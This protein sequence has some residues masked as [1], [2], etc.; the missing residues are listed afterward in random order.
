MNKNKCIPSFLIPVLVVYITCSRTE[1][2][3]S[4]Q[5]TH[6][7]VSV[8]VQAESQPQSTYL[9]TITADDMGKIGPNE[10]VGGET[11]RLYV[12]EGRRRT[13]SF[14]RYNHEGLLTDT[15]TSIVDISPGINRVAVSL[16][17][18]VSVFTITYD[19]NEFT[20]GNLPVD[21]SEYESGE[22]VT[23]MERGNLTKDGFCFSEWNSAADGSGRSYY[24]GDTLIVDT[25]DIRLY[26]LWTQPAVVT[27]GFDKNDSAATGIMD[28]QSIENGS[29]VSLFPN[30]FQKPGWTFAGW[31]TT[32]DGEVVFEDEDLISRA[33]ED[34]TLYAQWLEIA[35][36]TVAYDGN[37]NT[38]GLAPVDT[39]T[40]LPGETLT[41]KGQ[42]SLIRIG[43]SFTGWQL[44]LNG[45]EKVYK[46]NDTLVMGSSS[47]TLLAIWTIDT[48]SV[49]FNSDGGSPID[50][51][52]VVYDSV[53]SEP[54][55]PARDGHRFDG[56]FSNN[57]PFDFTT[58]ITAPITL[59]AK[60]TRFYT[61][62]YDA[63]GGAGEL[64]IDATAYQ[65]NQQG[66][67][68]P[69]GL[70]RYGYTFSGWNTKADY[71][72][73]DYGV[74]DSFFIGG[75]DVTLY[76]KWQLNS[77][78]ILT[79]PSDT[80]VMVG[81]TVEF[82]IDA[83]GA[84]LT[85][86][87]QH[88][89]TDFLH[90]DSAVLK[91]FI[92]HVDR[93]G[94]KITC[95]VSNQTDTVFSDTITITVLK[96]WIPTGPLE[97]MDG[98]VKIHAAGCRFMMGSNL[99]QMEAPPHIVEFTYD[100]WMDTTEVTQ[101]K[102]VDVMSAV[103]EDFS[104]SDWSRYVAGNDYPVFNVTWYD[105]ILYCNALTKL[106][107]SND[108][109]YS[110]TSVSGRLGNTDCILEGVGVDLSKSGYRLPTEA[111]WEYACRGGTKTDFFWESGDSSDYAW[112]DNSGMNTPPK[113]VALLLP[114]QYGLYDIIGNMAEWCN[115]WF[116]SF[117]PS[118]QINPSGPQNG[119]YKIIR[120]WELRS[121]YRCCPYPPE[122]VGFL[123]FRTV[124]PDR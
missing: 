96:Q 80:I 68:L 46:P 28:E 88:D 79:Q 78:E 54:D 12:P 117:D 11:I 60:W 48:F 58:R 6:P 100:F 18:A 76:A 5:N 4:V 10:Y 73:I 119:S 53:A 63:N 16:E 41:I 52:K 104:P 109:V 51:Q 23:I 3:F 84:E 36:Y 14:E 112:Y 31:A 35:N 7:E 47:R 114:N 94:E 9:I 1:S 37:G 29:E 8:S 2:P 74:R 99:D 40:Y 15:G 69:A 34:V 120:G 56:W 72:G 26:A 123:G 71:L 107:E 33:D 103:Y 105:A 66:R 91:T 43:H 85:Y 113:E 44:E 61:V 39:N 92:P 50:T 121:S 93:D 115:D 70:E 106:S 42:S 86:Q 45:D 116:D 82:R 98:M 59:K 17:R 24:E 20:D 25:T 108:T 32:R 55:E 75:G 101:K 111:E 30:Q 67:I 27:V 64:P 77:P 22:T 102:Y 122:Y 62:T 97:H 87:W 89:G 81:D 21:P 95:V 38:D 83:Y 13:F 19:G 57:V 124:R 90:G 118:T 49:I 65:S 110:Y